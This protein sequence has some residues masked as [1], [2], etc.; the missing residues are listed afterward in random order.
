MTDMHRLMRSLCETKRPPL[1]RRKREWQPPSATQIYLEKTLTSAISAFIGKTKLSSVSVSLP[2]ET[3]QTKLLDMITGMLEQAVAEGKHVATGR[4]E[5][6][7]ISAAKN[8]AGRAVQLISDIVDTLR[9]KAHDIINAVFGDDSIDNPEQVAEQQLEAW[10]EEYSTGVAEN[11]IQMA[12]NEAIYD[13]MRN[14][15][16]TLLDIVLD[17][18][19]CDV[20]RDIVGESPTVS[21][22]DGERLPPFHFK[23]RCGAIEHER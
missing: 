10:A 2:D 22:E 7:I 8:L 13:E 3:A 6:G 19:A 9:D 21:I 4:H 14:Q 23:C 18:D 17:P 16:T 12:V 5:R 15:G 20:C 11:E 1:Q